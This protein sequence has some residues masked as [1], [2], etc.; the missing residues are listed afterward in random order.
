M[1]N[2]PTHTPIKKG[3]KTMN[4]KLH[5]EAPA[6]ELAQFQTEDIITASVPNAPQLPFDPA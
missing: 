5:Y 1:A 4:N 3:G 2:L 6:L